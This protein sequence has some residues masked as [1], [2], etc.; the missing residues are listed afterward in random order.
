MRA[1]RFQSDRAS[2]TAA[3]R[4]VL[5]SV[6]A[7]NLQRICKEVL[8]SNL[9]A[10]MR[11]GAVTTQRIAGKKPKSVRSAYGQATLLYQNFR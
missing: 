4:G 11:K 3:S 1:T 10:E 6:A 7:A 5:L 8:C 2:Q 9:L